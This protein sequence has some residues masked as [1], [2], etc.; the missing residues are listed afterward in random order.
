MD[1][2]PTLSSARHFLFVCTGN[3]CRSPLAE[4]IARREA[5]IRGLEGLSFRSAGTHA[6]EG[7]PASEGSAAV[8]REAGL[9]LA[10]HTSTPLDRELLD[11]ADL[12]L[13]LSVSHRLTVEQAGGDRA[14]LVTRFLPEGHPE[15]GHPVLDPV[16]RGVD[17]YRDVREL[18]AEA[19]GGLLD[20]GE[21]AREED[22]L[23]PRSRT[24]RCPS[25]SS[26]GRSTTAS[27]PGSIG[28]RSGPWDGTPATWRSTPARPSWRG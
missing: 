23:V 15:R 16:G 4:A 2:L 24:D 6:S 5:R 27:R 12:V 19:V 18:L 26:D 21:A 14:V 7:A 11:W 1:E 22:P 25:R 13:C 9:D 28:G 8:G 20:R 17:V 3:T 10:S